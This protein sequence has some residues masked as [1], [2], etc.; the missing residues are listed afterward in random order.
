MDL[1]QLLQVHFQRG[2]CSSP[3]AAGE[4][5]VRRE[6]DEV[7]AR[8]LQGGRGEGI[9]RRRHKEEADK[10][11]NHFYI[12]PSSE[13][14]TFA[15]HLLSHIW[16]ICSALF[17]EIWS[18]FLKSESVGF[19]KHS[20]RHYRPLVDHYN[21]HW[22]YPV[23]HVSLMPIICI[24]KHLC[25]GEIWGWESCFGQWQ[26]SCRFKDQPKSSE[27]N[28]N[29]PKP[30]KTNQN[31]IKPTKP[32]IVSWL[33]IWC[34]IH[35]GWSGTLLNARIEHGDQESLSA[36]GGASGRGHGIL[37]DRLHKQIK[38]DKQTGRQIN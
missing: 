9:F 12:S 31:Q 37:A 24:L 11:W 7:E 6:K 30:T 35:T 8:H 36:P 38:T 25:L 23:L 15:A 16:D 3:L 26:C 19:W 34:E 14:R 21:S 20:L 33:I 5:N 18:P 27:T 13:L 28:Q 32:L 4:N 29:Q 22:K 2:S 10:R 1:H 17:W